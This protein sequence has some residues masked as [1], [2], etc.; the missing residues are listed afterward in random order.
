M[1]LGRADLLLDQVEIVEQPLGGG[2]D[3]PPGIQSERR[4]IETF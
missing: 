1:P 2:S 3:P 4:P